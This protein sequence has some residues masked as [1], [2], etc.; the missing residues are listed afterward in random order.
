MSRSAFGAL[1]ATVITA[2]AIATFLVVAVAAVILAGAA[3][4]AIGLA[5]LAVVPA[6]CARVY[7]FSPQA[8]GLARTALRFVV[9]GVLVGASLWYLDVLLATLIGLDDERMAQTIAAMSPV[10]V[11]VVVV[12]APAICEEILFRGVL[13]RGLATRFKPWAAVLISAAVFSLYHMNPPQFVPAFVLGLAFGTIAMC[14]GSVIPSMIAH[15][16]NNAAILALGAIGAPLDAH[17]WL[18][19]VIAAIATVAGLALALQRRPA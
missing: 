5:M 17:P 14:A 12:I 6:I 19:L 1:Q 2:I 7:G 4:L 15:A 8:L 16:L 10:V 9:A 18:T 13:L 11:I 3:G